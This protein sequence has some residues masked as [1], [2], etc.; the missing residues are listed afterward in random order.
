MLYFEF[1]KKY[2]GLLNSHLIKDK[3]LDNFF[4][5]NSHGKVQFNH[6]NNFYIYSY[7]KNIYKNRFMK[8][9]NNI[10]VN[11]TNFNI[12]LSQS[13]NIFSKLVKYNYIY[14]IFT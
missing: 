10:F 13:F 12:K 8:Y 3:I 6:K 11:K 7:N 5:F 1:S 4:Y 9:T 14:N 2:N